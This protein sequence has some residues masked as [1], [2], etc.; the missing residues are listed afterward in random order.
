MAVLQ[1]RSVHSEASARPRARAA[2]DCFCQVAALY[3]PRT[4]L[5]VTTDLRGRRVKRI[6]QSR[7]LRFARVGLALI[8][9]MAWGAAARPSLADEAQG[10]ENEEKRSFL[11]VTHNDRDEPVALEAAIVRFEGQHPDGG[12]LEV[13][14]V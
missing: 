8:W 3:L 13:E 7:T 2:G 14:L 12:R 1:A 9:A 5:F 4:A 10:K 11:R 6:A